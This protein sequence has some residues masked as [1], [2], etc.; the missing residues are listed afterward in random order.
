MALLEL[1]VKSP[2]A[3]TEI[4]KEV[5]FPFYDRGLSLTQGNISEQRDDETNV[6]M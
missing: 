4:D 5:L 6:W 1:L 2:A 3:Q